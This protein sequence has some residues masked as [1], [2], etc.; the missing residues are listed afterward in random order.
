MWD[1]DRIRLMIR[2]ALGAQKKSRLEM[3][4]ENATGIRSA[5]IRATQAVS[6]VT[7]DVGEYVIRVLGAETPGFIKV[8]GVNEFLEWAKQVGQ[9]NSETELPELTTSLTW[10]AVEQAPFN[11]N[12]FNSTCQNEKERAF[13]GKMCTFGTTLIDTTGSAKA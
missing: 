10:S 5:A 9:Y 7:G 1:K 6:T 12:N 13:V 3:A 11:I 4:R 8:N 2:L